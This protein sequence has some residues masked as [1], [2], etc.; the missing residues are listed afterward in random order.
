MR[1]SGVP[2]LALASGTLGVEAIPHAWAVGSSQVVGNLGSLAAG[3]GVVV[4][5]GVVEVRGVVVGRV[6]VGRAVVDHE[7]VGHGEA[8]H[9]N[10]PGEVGACRVDNLE[11][12]ED[13]LHREAARVWNLGVDKL[14]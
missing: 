14:G 6:V 10:G 1:C 7:L 11:G 3:R 2:A 5:H 8:D 4:G 13:A 9:A 12:P